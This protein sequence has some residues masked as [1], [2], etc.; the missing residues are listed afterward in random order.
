MEHHAQPAAWV[1]ALG[2]TSLAVAFAGALFIT[3]DIFGRGYRQKMWIMNLVYPITAL[4][5]GPVAV[6]FYVVHGRRNSQ[7]VLEKRGAPDP[8]RM[9]RWNV[10]SKAISHC[11][12]GCTLGD[13]AAE[14]LVFATGLTIAGKALYAD[15]ALDF[16]FAWVL[17]VVFQYFTIVPMRKI[18]RARGIWAAVKADTLSIIAFQV[19]LFLGMWIYQELFFAPGL[20]KTTATYWMLMQ[21]SMVFGFFTAWPVNAWLVR[22]GWK[23]KM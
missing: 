4:Y 22:K 9:P 23:E 1:E 6:W 19:G 7:P 18:G 20:P 14:W 5:W 11:G 13:I 16:V 12:A 3:V 8:E 2:W 17:G 15:F 21:V 10:L